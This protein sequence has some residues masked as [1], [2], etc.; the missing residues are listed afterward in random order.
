ME[1]G[2][3]TVEKLLRERTSLA[4]IT[5]LLMHTTEWYIVL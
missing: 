4:S 3:H 5:K 1:A 2:A